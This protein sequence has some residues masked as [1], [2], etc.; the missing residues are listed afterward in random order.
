MR[1]GAPARW[2]S[3]CDIFGYLRDQKRAIGL[4]ELV[5]RVGYSYDRSMIVLRELHALGIIHIH[6]W[7]P[8]DG[9]GYPAKMWKCWPGKD[10]KKPALVP[11]RTSRL[12]WYHGKI[13]RMSELYGEEVARKM[14][15]SKTC[16]GADQIVVDGKTVFRRQPKGGRPARSAA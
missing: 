15:Y 1:T 16:Y 7:V 9:G 10:A 3:H 2:P 11:K 5:K 13:K 6:S 8:A 4:P 12:R 14:V